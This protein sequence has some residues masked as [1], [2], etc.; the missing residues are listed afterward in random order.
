DMA[1]IYIHIPFCKQACHYCD[2]HFSTNTSGQERLIRNIEQELTIQREYLDGEKV[3]TVYFGGGTPSMISIGEL[4]NILETISKNFTVNPSSEITLEANPD[5][6]TFPKLTDL[7]SIGVNRLSIGI[8]SFDDDI[9]RF[10]NRAHDSSLAISSFGDARNAGFENI[11]I[12]LMYSLPGQD[13]KA[14]K[15]NIDQAL[16]LTP[17]HISAY[18]LTIEEKTV[19][20]KWA[21]TK[22]IKP[23]DDDASAQEMLL[24][25]D[26]LERDGFEHYEV[27]NFARPG[28]ISRHNSSYWKGEK[29]LGVGPSAH[30]YNGTS[31]QCNVSNNHLYS[32]AL[33][34]GKIPATMEVLSRTERINDFLLTTLRTSWGTDLRKMLNDHQ[35]DLLKFHGDYVQNLILGGYAALTNETLILTKSGRLLADKIA[36]DMFA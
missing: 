1:G 2:F 10:L 19:F 24:L 34:L 8:Q 16:G 26:E 15:K 35:Y 32:S 7:K 33:E 29:Y 28:Y 30:S 3:N 23:P 36:S 21:A 18:S 14:W 11:S 4:N 31:R 12:D 5:D 17:S 6:L 20:G 22:K 9:L 27:S 25:I 13:L